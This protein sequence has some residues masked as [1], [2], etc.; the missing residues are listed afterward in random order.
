MSTP[1]QNHHLEDERFRGTVKINNKN[2]DEIDRMMNIQI[3]AEKNK[4]GE[5][6][7]IT[8]TKPSR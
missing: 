6:R 1:F 8:E 7:M 2:K 5:K 3:K 4:K